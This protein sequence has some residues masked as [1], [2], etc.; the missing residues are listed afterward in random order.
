MM[1][2]AEPSGMFPPLTGFSQVPPP[3][4]LAPGPVKAHLARASSG[5]VEGVYFHSGS[6]DLGLQETV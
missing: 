3:C 5:G 6:Y 4:F 1:W 2:K